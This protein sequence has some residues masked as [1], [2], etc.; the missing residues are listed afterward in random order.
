MLVFSSLI[1]FHIRAFLLEK[2]KVF[3]IYKSCD[4][5]TRV[6]HTRFGINYRTKPILGKFELQESTVE[7]EWE[8]V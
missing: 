6:T 5:V 8:R 1:L 7:V 4:S 3:K 2:L